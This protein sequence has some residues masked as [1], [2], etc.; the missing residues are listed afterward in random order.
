MDF[1]MIHRMTVSRTF[2]KSSYFSSWRR[3][4]LG[5]YKTYDPKKWV[6]QPMGFASMPHSTMNRSFS[7][8][9]Y[10]SWR[11]SPLCSR[12]V[13]KTSDPQKWVVQPFDFP[14][15]PHTNV[16]KL[17]CKW[18]FWFSCRR[19][20]MVSKTSV[21]LETPRNGL[22]SYLCEVCVLLCRLRGCVCLP[23]CHEVSYYAPF[24]RSIIAKLLVL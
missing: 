1:A 23:S 19:C 8:N 11:R 6:V 22:F 20:P 14:M 5:S 9:A 15:I 7:T 2:F 3:C 17:F 12:G 10:F 16:S 4:R 21:R 24:L 13:S 18:A